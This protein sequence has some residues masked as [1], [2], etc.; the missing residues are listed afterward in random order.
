MINETRERFLISIGER[1]AATRLVEAFFFPA[2]RQGPL[3]TGV[4]VIAATAD[5][6]DPARAEVYTATYCWTRKGVERGKW[7]V[8]VIAVAH[9]P[10]AT[11]ETVVRGVQERSGEG[12]DAER[13]S[14]DEMRA[15][16]PA[17]APEPEA[18]AET[19][20]DAVS[21]AASETASEPASDTAD[22]GSAEVIAAVV[23]EPAA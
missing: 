16:L 10:L 12:I 18:P 8:D 9:A 4:A 22:D 7:T 15:V 2:I 3:E 19:V 21:E 17:P 11:V 6:S 14:G 20:A 13:M 23:A 5:A 1:V